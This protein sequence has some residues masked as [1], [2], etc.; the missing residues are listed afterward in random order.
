MVGARAK[1][2]LY[3]AVEKEKLYI[4]RGMEN[5]VFEV[6]AAGGGWI[7]GEVEVIRRGGFLWLVDIF[8]YSCISLSINLCCSENNIYM[9]FFF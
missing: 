2:I 9:T 6:A 8:I 7:E 3:S 1:R 4:F 5:F